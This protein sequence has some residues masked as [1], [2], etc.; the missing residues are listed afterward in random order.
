MKKIVS[1][2]MV[3]LLGFT[4]VVAQNNPKNLSFN[5]TTDTA[6]RIV[7]LDEFTA[8]LMPDGIPPMDEP[9]FRDRE[10]AENNYFAHKPVV[11]LENSGEAKAYPL[12]T[13]EETDVINVA[14]KNT[15]VVL[16]HTSKTVSV[17]HEENISESIQVG[18]EIFVI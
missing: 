13:F 15:P 7:S 10:K 8:L 16:F 4:I 1:I 6:N 11:A 14:F 5:W 3:F 2:A 17:V 12:S 18:S 9:K